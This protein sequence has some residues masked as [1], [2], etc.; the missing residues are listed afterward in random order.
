MMRALRNRCWAI[1]AAALMGVAAQSRAQPVVSVL[2]ESNPPFVAEADGTASGVCVEALRAA[3]EAAEL[4]YRIEVMP[5]VRAYANALKDPGVLLLAVARTPERE[6]QF[7]WIGPIVIN[8][9]ALFKRKGRS[10]IVVG[11]LD[12]A[13]RYRI[14]IVNQ[15]A[16]GIFLRA[17]GFAD[18]RPGADAGLA[19]VVQG[20]L[21]FPMLMADRID[22][23]PMSP[24][25][26]LAPGTDCSQIEPTVYLDGFQADM[27]MA[28]NA[29]TDDAVV[30]Q[31]RKGFETIRRNGT[32]AR[33]VK[34]IL[35]QF[36]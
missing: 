25:R 4:P 3:M 18:M 34:P 17:K 14:G 9:V 28:F 7:K 2:A 11:T 33:I 20:G 23:L 19:T 15:D 16:R 29:K 10:D 1:A 31:V 12:D 35:A 30:D 5:W 27:W 13:K 24:A 26:C 21:L 22:L 32:L 6:S 8:R 36:R